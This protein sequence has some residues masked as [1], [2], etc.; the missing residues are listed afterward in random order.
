MLCIISKKTFGEYDVHDIQTNDGWLFN[1]YGD[2]YAIVPPDM[3]EDIMVTCGFCDIE[4]NE[5]ETD[6]VSFT[7]KEKPEFEVVEPEPTTDEILNALLG[8]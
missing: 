5:D 7:A 6:I 2:E 1:P 4:L 8:V 3:V